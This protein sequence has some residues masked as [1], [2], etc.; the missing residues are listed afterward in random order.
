MP[1]ELLSPFIEEAIDWVKRIRKNKEFR[2]Q[3]LD[4]CHGVTRNLRMDWL[5]DGG[6][7]LNTM[8]VFVPVQLRLDNNTRAET[9]SLKAALSDNHRLVIMGLAG[10]G[11]ST[12]SKYIAALLASC[13]DNIDTQAMENRLK[14]E[15]GLKPLFPIHIDLTVC[16][17]GMSLDEAL[18][19]KACNADNSTDLV[20]DELIGG[21]CFVIFDGLDEIIDSRRRMK[22]IRE[23]ADITNRYGDDN[24]FMVTTRPAGYNKK[25]VLSGTAGYRHYHLAEWT[26]DQQEQFIKRYY[27][28]WSENGLE[29]TQSIDWEERAL[30][31]IGIIHGNVGLRRLKNNPLML[32]I[33]TYLS[34]RGAV[35]PKQEYKVYEEI[36]RYLVEKKAQDDT[37]Y[38]KVTFFVATLAFFMLE[39]ED[40]ETI[41][42][43]DLVG[44]LQKRGNNVDSSNIIERM[45]EEWGVIVNVNENLKGEPRYSF[46]SQSFQVYLAAYAANRHSRFWKR[47][48]QH[49]KKDY[50]GWEEVALMYASMSSTDEKILR[51]DQVIQVIL[52]NTEMIPY[53]DQISWVKAGRCIARAG[54]AGKRSR[55]YEHVLKRLQELSYGNQEVNIQSVE[56]LCQIHP[57]GSEFILR[58]IMGYLAPDNNDYA[59]WTSLQR[60]NDSDAKQQLRHV[61]V[62]HIKDYSLSDR[63]SLAK[64]LA[65]IGDDRLGRFVSLPHLSNHD[66]LLRIGMYP[67]TNFEYAKFIKETS[68]P[69]PSHWGS[70]EYPAEKANHPVTHI[71]QQD[72]IEYCK[73]L[74][75]NSQFPTRLPS[76]E[77][78]MYAANAGN[79]ELKFP[80]ESPRI[81]GVFLN[82]RGII[83][84]T[85]PVGIYFEGESPLG[86]LDMMGN[87]WEWTADK[88]KGKAVLK[89]GAWDTS[90]E[91]LEEGIGAARMERAE[92]RENNIGFRILQEYTREVD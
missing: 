68:Y 46:I 7:R 92:R 29:N 26:D 86:V 10:A 61:I 33:I 20:R 59:I 84:G 25:R 12:L 24:Y 5:P 32:S 83:G 67:V 82:F 47:L 85:T 56:V 11:K 3:Y 80:W 62:E 91:E 65:L 77:E 51:V 53:Q 55:W 13:H 49:L 74:T 19:A 66:R 63:I 37:D 64:A 89:G 43:H 18:F 88:R 54:E 4:A 42:R 75:E 15:L 2:N 57:E 69:P 58:R 87:V 70:R 48:Q 8:D 14:R 78:W 40:R 44:W 21:N 90:R 50:K 41:S 79:S 6:Y 81:G 38:E 30:D 1:L 31:L 23:I 27:K 9:I 34:F 17:N 16:N 72:A 22:V 35:M 36:I 45:E 71:S 73:W 76:E 60:M 39:Q 52:R 28:L